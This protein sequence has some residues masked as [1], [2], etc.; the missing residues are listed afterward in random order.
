MG[1]LWEIYGRSMEHVWGMHGKCMG[2]LSHTLPPSLTHTQTHPV[3]MDPYTCMDPYIFMNSYKS[4]ES[5]QMY[6]SMQMYKK[7]DGDHMKSI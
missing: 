7:P 5:I 3:L 1:N 4:Y 6:G 2:N